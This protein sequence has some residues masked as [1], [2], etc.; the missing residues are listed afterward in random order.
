MNGDARTR[1]KTAT[2]A[3]CEHDRRMSLK[4]PRDD[5]FLCVPAGEQASTLVDAIYT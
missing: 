4:F 1:I 2:R 3:L 5:Q